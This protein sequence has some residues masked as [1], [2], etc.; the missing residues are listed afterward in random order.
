MLIVTHLC[1]YAEE[2]DVTSVE[3]YFVPPSRTR[4]LDMIVVDQLAL[5]LPTAYDTSWVPEAMVVFM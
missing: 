3:V 5:L 1:A 2:P 4:H